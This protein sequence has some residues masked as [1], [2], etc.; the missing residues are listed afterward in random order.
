VESGFGKLGQPYRGTGAVRQRDI[1]ERPVLVDATA[2]IEEVQRGVEGT[3]P[4]DT[5]HASGNCCSADHCHTAR[6][7]RVLSAAT[8][9]ELVAIPPRRHFGTLR[10]TDA[11]ELRGILQSRETDVI[12]RNA[13][14]GSTER[15]L[16]LL[17]RLPPFLERCEVPSLALSADYPQPALRRIKCQPAADGKM[18]DRL[19][20]AE[21]TITEEAR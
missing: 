16:A 8:S 15:A 7:H 14:T 9:P 5:E 1:H 10:L 17:D 6:D 2:G 4:D 18:L 11:D 13:K 12:R 20:G 21:R 3:E 19:I